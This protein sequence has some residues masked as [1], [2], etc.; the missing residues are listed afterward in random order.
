MSTRN[1]IRSWA[2]GTAL[3][4]GLVASPAHAEEWWERFYFR[5]G[6]LAMLPNATSGPVTLS[7]VTGNARLAISDGPIAGS[8]AGLGSTG[9]PCLTIGYRIWDQ[10][11]AETILAL[12]F[13][14]KLTAT[15]TLATQSLAG[16]ALGNLPTGVAPLGTDLGQ[17]TVL[18]PILTFTYRFLPDLPVHPYVGLGINYLYT[19]DTKIT[20]PTL[21]AVHPINLSLP[22]KLGPV[23]QG[24]V[25]VRI[26][27]QLYVTL[28]VKYIPGIS[29]D[30]AMNN[31]DVQVPGLPL[32]GVVHVGNST[33]HVSLNP[34]VLQG[35]VGWNF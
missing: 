32:Y 27:R 33:V 10:L 30:V 9:L 18:P 6:A 2:L 1:Q 12:P 19:Y 14:M 15:G 7:G 4:A 13:T 11:T 21:T 5:A 35:G 28:D 25:D 16:T 17:T 8:G 3:L 23:I 34:V 20:N 22:G 26:W 29:L 24:G 31:L